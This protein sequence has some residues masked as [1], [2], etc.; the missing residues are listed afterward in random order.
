M[1]DTDLVQ[2]TLLRG[3]KPDKTGAISV[4]EHTLSGYYATYIMTVKYVSV[5]K[6]RQSSYS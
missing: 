1:V 3:E 6:H 5:C 4:S 2:R